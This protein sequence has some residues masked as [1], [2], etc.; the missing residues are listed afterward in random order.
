MR[1]GREFKGQC[2]FEGP[3]NRDEFLTSLPARK[4]QASGAMAVRSRSARA[5]IASWLWIGVAALAILVW[6]I[7]NVLANVN[8][9]ISGTVTDPSG[10]VVVGA[11]VEAKAIDTGLVQ[12]R[13]TNGDGFYVFSDLPPGKY[14]IEVR[15]QGFSTYKQTDL[16]LDVNAAQVINVK[17]VVGSETL[18]VTVQSSTVTIETGSTQNGE[19]IT[20]ETIVGVPLVTRSYT[21]LLALQPGVVP[22]SSGLSG[23]L[24]GQFTSSGFAFPPVS[25]DLNAGNL[26]VNGGREG[27][28]G[29]LLNGITVQEAAFSGAG[30]IPN[31]DSIAEFRIL[32]NNFDSEY[33]NYSGGQINVITKSGTNGFHGNLFEFLRNTAFD[34]K[35]FFSAQRDDHKQ[36]QF[37]GTVGGPIKRDKIFFFGDYQGNR[38]IIGQSGQGRTPVPS[39]AE[40]LGDFSAVSSKLTGNVQGPAWAQTLSSTLGYA[41]TQ[42]EPYYTTSCTTTAQCVF[43]GAQIP[44]TAFSVPSKNLLTYIPPVTSTGTDSD[45]NPI[46]YYL[47]NVA[48]Q[49]ITDNKASGRVDVNSRFGL[50]SSYYFFDQFLQIN[51]NTFLPGFGSNY[52]GRTQFANFGDT[53]TIGNNSVNEFRFGY[54]RIKDVLHSPTGGEGVTPQSLGF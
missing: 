29:F 28:N 52:K 27:A 46:S 54:I 13:V 24:P 1:P 21:D 2:D 39:A 22:V 25:G 31:L 30:A 51:P 33:G 4:M 5:R 38:V 48:P 16:V 47:P 10:A 42:G 41:V 43:P 32:T 23:G 14:N 11:T 36:N 6:P 19:V 50:L 45:G 18:S 20:G 3:C 35:N 40:R 53:K 7:G 15:Q 12:T 26:S 49:R 17:L 34:A 9:T 8:A 44:T 37:G